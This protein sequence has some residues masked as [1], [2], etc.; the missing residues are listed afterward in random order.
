MLAAL[1][2]AACG[3]DYKDPYGNSIT[4]EEHEQRVA[5]D[6][7]VN[8]LADMMNFCKARPDDPQCTALKRN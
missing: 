1:L 8:A 2:L 4:K 3:D 7:A 5:H 6:A